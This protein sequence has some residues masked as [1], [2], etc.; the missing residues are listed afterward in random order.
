MLYLE[1]SLNGCTLNNRLLKCLLNL[2]F[3]Q[4]TVIFLP[5]DIFSAIIT[6]SNNHM[7]IQFCMEGPFTN[8]K[9]RNKL[10]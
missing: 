9:N 4:H 5:P 6:S 3:T 10:A 8:S 1:Y 7:H 2:S